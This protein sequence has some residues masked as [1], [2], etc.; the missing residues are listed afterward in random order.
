MLGEKVRWE[1]K[2]VRKIILSGEKNCWKKCFHQKKNFVTKRKLLGK[3]FCQTKII[4]KK[5]LMEKKL[6]QIL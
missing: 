4:L 3:I 1:Q 2:V 5:F 6:S